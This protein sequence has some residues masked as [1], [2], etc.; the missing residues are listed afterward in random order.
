MSLLGHAEGPRGSCRGLAHLVT[1]RLLT[2]L[3]MTATTFAATE[4]D[5]P[6]GAVR[7]HRENG[8]P[9]PWYGQAYLPAGSST[10]TT[11]RDMTL[12]TWAVLTNQAPGMA[13]LDPE[14]ESD[15]GQIGLAWQ[16]RVPEPGDHLAQRRT[17]GMRSMLALDRE[18]QQGVMLGNTS[19]WVNR[20]GLGLAA[21][22]GPRC[23]R[24]PRAAGI[25][26]LIAIA[27]G[28]AFLVS[29]VSAALR[30]KDQLAVAIGLIS[31]LS[32]LLILLAYGP[33]TF[34]PAWI[35]AR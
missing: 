29:F 21:S 35:W 7:G 16:I 31:G 12:F 20:A 34:A 18:Q 25:P 5:I 22:D 28:L 27:V 13:A 17:G 24:P 15:N 9:A 26:G 14:A 30:G 19:R 11:A 10:W 8:W 6:S 32:G 1:D 4:A 33:W 3:R 23:R 2:P